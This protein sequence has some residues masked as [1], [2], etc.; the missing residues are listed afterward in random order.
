M[1]RIEDFTAHSS[2][3]FF[4]HFRTIPIPAFSPHLMLDYHTIKVDLIA[5]GRTQVHNRSRPHAKAASE[6]SWV[7]KRK[8]PSLLGRLP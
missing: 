4:V 8:Q 7:W 3:C 1:R 6:A 5:W 2:R